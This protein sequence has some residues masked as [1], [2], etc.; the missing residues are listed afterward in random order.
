MSRIL[1]LAI[2]LSLAGSSATAQ[3]T[4]TYTYDVHGRLIAADRSTGANTDYAYDAGDSR[5]SKATTGGAS[6]VAAVA[7]AEISSPET[8]SPGA[9]IEAEPDAEATTDNPE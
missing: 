8:V 1:T 6:S 9:A 7:D 3:E 2:V 4:T 5:T